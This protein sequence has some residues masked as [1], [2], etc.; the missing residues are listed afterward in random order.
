MNICDHTYVYKIDH[1][2]VMDYGG[3][4]VKGTHALYLCS[5]CGKQKWKMRHGFRKVLL[6]RKL[7][8]NIH[9]QLS[10]L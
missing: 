3:T 9:H 1:M 5:K 8:K 6:S 4:L 10:F 2:G 7:N